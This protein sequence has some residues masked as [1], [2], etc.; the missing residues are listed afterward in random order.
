VKAKGG[1]VGEGSSKW[2]MPLCETKKKI[3]KG[4]GLSLWTQRWCRLAG[5]L[6]RLWWPPPFLRIWSLPALSHPDLGVQTECWDLPLWIGRSNGKWGKRVCNANTGCQSHNNLSLR[7]DI[8][9]G[10]L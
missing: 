2:K 8:V 5:S 3:R 9:R 1:P 6:V 10:Y 7:F 4:F